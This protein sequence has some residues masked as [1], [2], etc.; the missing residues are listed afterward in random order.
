LG[1]NSSKILW[2]YLRDEKRDLKGSGSTPIFLSMRQ[3]GVGLTR[4]GLLQLITDIGE[5]AG[6]TGVRCSPHT[7]R[8]TFAIEFLRR[9]TNIYALKEILGHSS[10][11]MCKR[12]LMMVQA[13][14]QEQHRM[15]SPGD[16]MWM[17]RAT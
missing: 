15:Y 1:R 10:L 12:Y 16:F 6:I 14:I 17:E 2:N 8:H 11:D 9:T 5:A 3:A 13:D 4:S 7:F